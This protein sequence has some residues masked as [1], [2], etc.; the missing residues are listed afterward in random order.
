M[1]ARDII[2]VC[3]DGITRF[4][5][6]CAG[7]VRSIANASGVLLFGNANAIVLNLGAGRRL[8]DGVAAQRA[9]AAGELVIGGVQESGHGHVVVVVDGPM[10]RGRYPYAFWGQYHGLTI[11]R[12]TT[13]VGFTR[14]HGTINYAFNAATRDSVQYAAFTP[15]A[16][17][18]PSATPGKGLLV[19]IFT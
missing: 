7:F 18:L 4:P 16:G 14:G 15:V 6:D 8:H 13:N 2:A 1:A 10:N 11:S 17:L 3:Q 9:A 19:H 12:E 5:N